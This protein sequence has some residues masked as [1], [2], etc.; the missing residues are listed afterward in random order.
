MVDAFNLGKLNHTQGEKN[1]HSA[2]NWASHSKRQADA[3]EKG[4]LNLLLLQ[5]WVWIRFKQRMYLVLEETV[6]LYHAHLNYVAPNSHKEGS[7]TDLFRCLLH[8]VPASQ[9]AMYVTKPVTTNEGGQ[10]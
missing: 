1:V 2:R 9:W 6:E 3:L 7:R 10:S 5:S 8:S 4:D